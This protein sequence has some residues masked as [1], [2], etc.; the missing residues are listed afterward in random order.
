[1]FTPLEVLLLGLGLVLFLLPL[2]RLGELRRT[3][4]H[5]DRAGRSS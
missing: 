2:I 3:I 4:E 5:T 1:M